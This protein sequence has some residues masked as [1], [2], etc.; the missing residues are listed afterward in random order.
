M[1]HP[2]HIHTFPTS[3][4][5]Q[6]HKKCRGQRSWH[7]LGNCLPPAPP[8]PSSFMPYS[9]TTL[10]ISLSLACLGS[11]PSLETGGLVL[12]PGRN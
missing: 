1:R 2:P 12:N 8:P 11:L 5:T 9:E 3:P 4:P 7:K 10:E 6:P